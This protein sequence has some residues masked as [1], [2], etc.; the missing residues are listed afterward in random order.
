MTPRE[1]IYLRFFTDGNVSLDYMEKIQVRD[2]ILKSDKGKMLEWFPN[3]VTLP[4]DF[5]DDIYDDQYYTLPASEIKVALTYVTSLIRNSI[6]AQDIAV[7]NDLSV[8]FEKASTIND[9]SK[10]KLQ[11]EQAK[12]NDISAEMDAT[13]LEAKK[14]YTT[15]DI[16]V[17]G[18]ETRP[19]PVIAYQ[20]EVQ[21]KYEAQLANDSLTA[22]QLAEQKA[23][24]EA[25]Q[26]A[27]ETLKQQ[28]INE[29]KANDAQLAIDLENAEKARL[30]A[31]Q[32]YAIAEQKAKDGFAVNPNDKAPTVIVEKKSSKVP[33]AIGAGVLALIF[34]NSGE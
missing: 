15:Y 3:F 16:L 32:D 25:A 9:A 7:L 17:K 14:I 12:L 22:N 4:S 1:E 13:L 19:D 31:L 20:K 29:Q 8:K 18:L 23:I 11:E 27:A 33:L 34:M 21:A 26:V 28:V 24:Q 6:F 30:Q 10:L 2:R 5:K